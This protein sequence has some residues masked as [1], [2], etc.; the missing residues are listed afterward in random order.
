MYPILGTSASGQISR[1]AKSNPTWSVPET[2]DSFD[3]VI[4]EA[5]EGIFVENHK[6]HD[7]RDRDDDS[8][9]YCEDAMSMYSYGEDSSDICVLDMKDSALSVPDVLMKDLDEAHAATKLVTFDEDHISLD[10]EGRFISFPP[11]R[12]SDQYSSASSVVSREDDDGEDSS[13]KKHERDSSSSCFAAKYH[14]IFEEMEILPVRSSD[15]A[16]MTSTES[17][18][19]MTGE[20]HHDRSPGDTDPSASTKKGKCSTSR[21]SNKKR[22]KKLRMLKKA[23]AAA[24]AAT[25]LTKN[26]PQ[27]TTNSTS[28]S[29]V[30]SKKA[31]SRIQQSQVT[32]KAKSRTIKKLG[33]MAVACATE[34]IA[35]YRDELILQD[36]K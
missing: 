8:Y 23:Q 30:A 18:M 2:N 16:K 24:S 22:R 15:D 9:D 12:K 7:G 29:K 34:T 1:N 6:T 27:G 31:K 19:E 21:T 14:G 25:T 20:D 5:D 3:F 4:I 26:K 35:A 33:N 36:I 32:Q 10:G 13:P 28:T 11:T 17:Q